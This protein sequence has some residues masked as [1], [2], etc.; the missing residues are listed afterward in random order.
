MF[1]YLRILKILWRSNHLQWPALGQAEDLYPTVYCLAH[2]ELPVPNSNAGRAIEV[3]RLVSKLANSAHKSAVR[4][5]KHLNRA[6]DSVRHIDKVEGGLDATS[7]EAGYAATVSFYGSIFPAIWS[8]QLALR[9]RGLGS[10]LTTLHLTYQEESRAIL[11]L[12]DDVAQIALIPVAY[13]RGLNFKP[14]QRPP[15]ESITHFN[16]WNA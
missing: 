6:I 10:V 12:P 16:G 7:E 8:F 3:A 4:V 2:I 13:T 11:G 1:T 5:P 15:A 14:T 9:S